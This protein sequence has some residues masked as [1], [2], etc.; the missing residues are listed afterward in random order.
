MYWDHTEY[1]ETWADIYDELFGW[2]EDTQ[3]SV[4]ALARIASGN[5]VLELGAGTGRIAIPLAQQGIEV[6]AVE[7][8]E[9][10]VKLLESKAA[11]VQAPITVHRKNMCDIDLGVK[12]GVVFM[13]HNTLSALATQDEQI[14]CIRSAARHVRDNGTLV[15]DQ[16][17]PGIGALKGDGSLRFTRGDHDGVWVIGQH[18]DWETQ[19][20]ISQRIRIARDRF[21]SGNIKSRYVWPSELDLMARLAGLRACARW[22]DWDG[23][24]FKSS[25][26]TIISHFQ[27]ESMPE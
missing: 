25:S 7:V 12:F 9:K 4:R 14:M 6:H 21:F 19:Q 22:S 20:I 8:S 18:H 24:E 2:C 5:G 10:M 3:P 15:I 27:L 16:G 13:S 26:R 1:G 23:N 17:I 11:A